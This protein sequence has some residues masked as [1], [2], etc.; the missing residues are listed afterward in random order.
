MAPAGKG[1]LTAADV[2]RW[3]RG[4]QLFHVE[5]LGTLVVF[6]GLTT[7]STLAPSDVRCTPAHPAICG[8]SQPGN[9]A[10]ALVVATP[11]LL[12][13]APALGC[14]GALACSVLVA[15]YDPEHL[16][17]GSWAAGGILAVAVLGHLT[18]I[19]VRQHRLLTTRGERF[20]LA[21]PVHN[22]TPASSRAQRLSVAALAGTGIVL[23]LIYQHQLSAK[24]HHL[25][26]AQ[27]LVA[28]VQSRHGSDDTIDL[29][30]PAADVPVT[31]DVQTTG[32]YHDGQEVPVLADLTGNQPWVR[33]VAE[34]EDPGSWL[35]FGILA[36]L[37]AG[38]A[39]LRPVRTWWAH[40]RPID[41][42]RRALRVALRDTAVYPP[43]GSGPPMAR[44]RV[45][46]ELIVATAGH[47]GFRVRPDRDWAQ[48]QPAFLIG[49]CWYGGIVHMISVDGQAGADA[50]LGLPQ[51]TLQHAWTTAPQ[52][53]DF[54]RDESPV[55]TDLV[56]SGSA[57]RV[58]RPFTVYRTH[59]RLIGWICWPLCAV[60]LVGTLGCLVALETTA[61]GNVNSGYFTGA[62]LCGLSLLPLALITYTAVNTRLD[63]NEDGVTVVNGPRPRH[64]PWSEVDDVMLELLPAGEG[65]SYLY[66]LV[67]TTPGGPVRA[68]APLGS[69][70]PGGQLSRLAATILRY[71]D[72]ARARTAKW[73]ADREAI[74]LQPGREPE[75]PF[76]RQTPSRR[77]GRRSR[78]QHRRE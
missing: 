64:I 65:V 75:A 60:L 68:A 31:V 7:F 50:V 67:F 23:L 43:D 41:A 28:V 6:L 76:Q 69:N 25:Q 33:L 78:A 20:A 59:R 66:Q 19:R 77:P 61:H 47:R 52:P 35:S 13:C 53:F 18:L 16:I 24:Q 9:W 17:H 45:V 10:F 73:S 15:R 36:L 3:L 11:V 74:N 54:E 56:S 51:L 22:A 27:R 5:R 14:L 40:R 26:H 55:E 37:L 42:D 48:Q 12:L 46:G 57:A 71:R 34:P 72:Q 58:L 2:Q 30:V 70:S 1:E 4:L 21:G 38:V 8:P 29:R 63:V 39:A 49:Q 32:N 44:L 62:L